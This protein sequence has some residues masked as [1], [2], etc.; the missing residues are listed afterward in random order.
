MQEMLWTFVIAILALIAIL[1]FILVAVPRI[2]EFLRKGLEDN[3]KSG[4][5][6]DVPVS[7]EAFEVRFWQIT[8]KDIKVWV[9]NSD[10]MIT[11][12]RNG[13]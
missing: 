3:L 13:L 1:G 4:L 12:Y 6:P 7:V 2:D 9:S 5:G 10:F 11:D 8:I